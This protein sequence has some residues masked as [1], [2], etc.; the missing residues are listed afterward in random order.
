M[1]ERRSE[2]EEESGERR[3]QTVNS[4]TTVG[5]LSFINKVEAS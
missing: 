1:P 4:C 3:P 5:A 2:E